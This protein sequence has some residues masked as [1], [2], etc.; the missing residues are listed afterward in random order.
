MS[1]MLAA[2][3]S[4]C[5]LLVALLPY[6]AMTLQAAFVHLPKLILDRL[7]R[8]NKCLVI[9]NK[10]EKA[11]VITKQI[12][13]YHN[14]NFLLEMTSNVEEMTTKH[15]FSSIVTENAQHSGM[16]WSE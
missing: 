6:Q 5:G 3:E 10:T 15:S 7:P 2:S 16:S 8:Q 13:N 12:L 9:Y 4:I 1:V 14:A 11:L